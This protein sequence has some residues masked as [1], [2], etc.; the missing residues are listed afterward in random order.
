[1]GKRL[2]LIA[3]LKKA[4]EFKRGRGSNEDVGWSGRAKDTTTDEN[5]KVIHIRVMCNKMR[6]MQSI[7]SKVGI[8]FG[9]VQSILADILGIQRFHE[10]GCH[11][12]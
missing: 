8:R 1:M 10:D 7:A 5:V 11:E 12:F 2:L 4:A 9:A 3:Q 6:D